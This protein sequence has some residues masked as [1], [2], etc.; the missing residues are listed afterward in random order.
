MPLTEE[1]DDAGSGQSDLLPGAEAT[2]TPVS[3]MGCGLPCQHALRLKIFEDLFDNPL[4]LAPGSHPQTAEHALHLASAVMRV[5]VMRADGTF[6]P[7]QR[8]ADADG[9]TSENER[10]VR[11]RV[12]NPPHVPQGARAHSGLRAQ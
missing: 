12:S 3:G 10:H 4:P 2:T 7:G 9:H 6:H 5:E 11:W 8:V 1:T